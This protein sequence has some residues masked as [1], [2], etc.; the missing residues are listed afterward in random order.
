ML[1]A[2]LG[3]P[4]PTH[5]SLLHLWASLTCQQSII[6]HRVLQPRI[7]GGVPRAWQRLWLGRGSDSVGVGLG[8]ATQPLRQRVRGHRGVVEHQRHPVAWADA[9]AVLYGEAGGAA[10][11]VGC[12]VG[13]KFT[14]GILAGKLQG[15]PGGEGVCQ[16][17]SLPQ[18]IIGCTSQP[19]A[20][21]GGACPSSPGTC[22]GSASSA[23]HGSTPPQGAAHLDEGAAE[24]PSALNV[25]R[26]VDRPGALLPV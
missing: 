5:S 8:A 1:P 6:E 18:K 15:G 2:A 12:N 14:D 17:M 25:A 7:G 16:G 10:G 21:V 4:G 26:W 19:S 9:A 23:R 20:G 13:E 11:A 24:R 22:Y 3:R